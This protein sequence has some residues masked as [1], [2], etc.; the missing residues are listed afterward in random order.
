MWLVATGPASAASYERGFMYS[1]WD[2]HKQETCDSAP[3]T[4]SW[5]SSPA[6]RDPPDDREIKFKENSRKGGALWQLY[7]R[8]QVQRTKSLNK[9]LHPSGLCPSLPKKAINTNSASSRHPIPDSGAC[10]LVQ[11]PSFPRASRP[12]SQGWPKTSLSWLKLESQSWF[13]MELFGCSG[14]QKS[15][16][17]EKNLAK[18]KKSSTTFPDL[19]SFHQENIS[20]AH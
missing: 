13:V 10:C 20:S 3:S 12:H 9:N 16:G 11:P 6:W 18:K 19:E 2:L 8:Q 7:Q 14:V 17:E 1:L 4:T 5:S 15:K